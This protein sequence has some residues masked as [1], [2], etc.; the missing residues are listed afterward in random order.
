MVSPGFSSASFTSWLFTASERS[1]ASFRRRA[2]WSW[3]WTAKCTSARSASRGKLKSA[4]SVRP[5]RATWPLRSSTFRPACGPVVIC[6]ESC[7]PGRQAGPAR[8]LVHHDRAAVEIEHA[9]AGD[10]GLRP[11]GL[12]LAVGGLLDIDAGQLDAAGRN[13]DRAF[14][15]LQQQ[16][17][18]GLNRSL[19]RFDLDRLIALGNRDRL[20]ALRDRDGVVALVDDRLAVFFLDLELVG[21]LL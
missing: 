7:I 11:R 13:L 8:F 14:A 9:G 19:A 20:V 5:I 1:R 18:G 2:P 15:D 12:E 21:A 3:H 6:S 4:H 16:L 17:L 10:F